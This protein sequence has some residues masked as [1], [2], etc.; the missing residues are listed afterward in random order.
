VV[1][2]APLLVTPPEVYAY[3][4]EPEAMTLTGSLSPYAV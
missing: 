3:C 2:L 4:R 1:E